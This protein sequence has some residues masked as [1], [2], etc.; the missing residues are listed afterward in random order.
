MKKIW[1]LAKI[2]VL[3]LV[4]GIISF[5]GLYIYALITPKLDINKAR[6][7]YLYDNNEQLVFN[8]NDEWINLEDISDNL[9]KAT[10]YTE[11]K[12][13]YKHSGFDILRI[14]KA[15]YVN[16]LSGSK[17]EGASTITQQYAR[18]LFLNFDKTWKRKFDE[19][20]LAL[21]IEA[22]Y[23]K[24]EILEGYLNTINYGGVFGIEN[25]AK[26]Y[27]GK[28]ASDLNLA[29]ATMLA[30][31]PKS[32]NVYSPLVNSK[33]AKE[34]QKLI[35]SIL[36]DNGV[37][38]KEEYDEALRLELIYKS[39]EDKESL[40]SVMY[41]Q[42]AVVQELR[43]IKEIPTSMLETGGLKVYTTLDKEAQRYLEE[44]TLKY[45]NGDTQLQSAGIIMNPEN[46]NVLALM[47]GVDYNKS[48]FNRAT[49]SVRQVGSTM[50]PFLYYA[51]L[52]N[53]FTASSSFLSERTTFTFSGDKTYS[54]KNYNDKYPNKQI[55]LAAAI[56][57]SDNVFAVKTHL[58]LGENVLVDMAKRVGIKGQLSAI[59]SLAL[60][61][62][63]ISMID[64]IGGYA[65]FANE[66][67]KVEPHFIEKV[68]DSKGNIIYEYKEVK[69][70]V[71]N[72]SVTYILNE[73]LTYT[74]D[75]SFIDYNYPTVISLLPE[76]TH[77]Y[78]VKT[79]TTDTDLWIIG[80]NKKAVLGIWNGYDDNRELSTNDLGH[81][82]KIW[83]ETMEN[84]LKD[85]DKN[86]EWYKTPSNV[87]GVL[88]DPISGEPIN[89]ASNKSKIFYFIK[90]TEPY[91]NNVDLDTVF[92]EENN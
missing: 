57:Y 55:S 30:G 44:A 88:V 31:I 36:L 29:E 34:R 11:D 43:Q 2:L 22:H 12:R 91:Y 32:P 20:I 45:I 26:Y 82:K 54:P 60:G 7:Y 47:G 33:K 81:H 6:S 24:E 77:K 27:F 21:E 79:G 18:N 66:G 46:G 14:L 83:I 67:Y 49:S 35:L 90:G 4:F 72:K 69:V 40:N 64:M 5:F 63:E 25:A 78:A 53:G 92:N 85:S 8:D 10:I 51:A 42:D 39:F 52:E 76:M 48:Q 38:S 71:L 41:F 87:V 1:K 9:V 89:V 16:L 37:I 80:Y 50:K 28:S 3:S 13:F 56:S 15:V 70:G 73:L 74:Y 59:P 23:K 58:F 86:S 68:V 62:E 75:S 61:S 17:K 65:C 19:A 84:Y